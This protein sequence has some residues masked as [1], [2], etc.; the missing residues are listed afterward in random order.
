M[1]SFLYVALFIGFVLCVITNIVVRIKKGGTTAL[2]VKMASSM[3][4]VLLSI[5]AVSIRPENYRFGIFFVIGA[6]FGMLGDTLLDLQSIHKEQSSTYFLAGMATFAVGHIFYI[7]GI[8]LSYPEFIGWQI[9]LAIFSA[10]A[11]TAI[12]RLISN[13]MKFDY[14]KYSI[15]IL[16]YSVITMLTVTFSLNA[17]NAFGTLP[18]AAGEEMPEI[19][20]RFIAMFVGTAMFAIS[21]LVL[22]IFYFKN[23]GHKKSN[24]ALNYA[25]YYTSQFILS[26]SI[27]M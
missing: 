22:S 14:G 15:F 18:M 12:F 6:V 7:V 3:I 20:P 13:K 26:L 1:L 10:T 24:V 17:M 9:A 8:L 19:M 25:L 2:F 23:G 11:V 4:F 21:D 27:L 5:T 16:L